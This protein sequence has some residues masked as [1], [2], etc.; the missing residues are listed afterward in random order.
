MIL[1]LV[2]LRIIK[3]FFPD[4][5]KKQ[6]MKQI[7]EKSHVSREPVYRYLKAFVKSN[8]VIHKKID[9][10]NVFSLNLKNPHIRN[11][12]QL[13]LCDALEKAKEDKDIKAIT[14]SAS[15]LGTRQNVFAA[16]LFYPKDKNKRRIIYVTPEKMAPDYKEAVKLSFK[17]QGAVNSMFLTLKEFVESLKEEGNLDILMNQALVLFGF[18]TVVDSIVE[19]LE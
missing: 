12:L 6:T 13:F 16:I 8:Y 15:Q 9:S 5:T 4:I 19:S 17:Y 14:E 10:L 2:S 11:L 1:R 3:A 7:C 18:E